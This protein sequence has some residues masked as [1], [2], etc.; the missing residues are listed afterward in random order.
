[1]TVK[2][3]HATT[4]CQRCRPPFDI[5]HE[6]TRGV[7][8]RLYHCR[9]GATERQHESGRGISFVFVRVVNSRNACMQQT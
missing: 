1:V 8:D 9:H 2:R 7:I 4:D 5:T 3:T 6:R